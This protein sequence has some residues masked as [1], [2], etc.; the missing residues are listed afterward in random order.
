MIEYILSTAL[1]YLVGFLHKTL[2]GKKALHTNVYTQTTNTHTWDR[3]LVKDVWRKDLSFIQY[4]VSPFLLIL[5]FCNICVQGIIS[6]MLLSIPKQLFIPIGSLI[7]LR[8]PGNIKVVVFLLLQIYN[9]N[10]TIVLQTHTC[11]IVCLGA[12]NSKCT[13]NCGES[14]N[15]RNIAINKNE[16]SSKIWKAVNNV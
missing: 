14:S 8:C 6:L 13:P 12:I 2:K 11:T 9:I 7:I 10:E 1:H 5:L 15:S 3:K 4:R 16:T